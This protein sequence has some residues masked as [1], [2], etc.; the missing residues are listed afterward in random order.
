MDVLKEG[1]NYVQYRLTS[2]IVLESIQTAQIS[3]MHEQFCHSIQIMFSDL[4]VA[5]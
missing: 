2:K 1:T 3:A 4:T 5:R